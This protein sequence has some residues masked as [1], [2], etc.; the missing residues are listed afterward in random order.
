VEVAVATEF[1]PEE[2]D[3]QVGRRCHVEQVMKEVNEAEA[4]NSPE[5]V[6]VK[7]RKTPMM[8]T[9]M[10]IATP[11]LDHVTAALAVI[12]L[13]NLWKGVKE[14]QEEACRDQECN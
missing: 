11:I 14:E 8:M 1:L 5:V 3:V 2:S 9:Q 6:L 10:T 12:H 7:E 4:M 13:G